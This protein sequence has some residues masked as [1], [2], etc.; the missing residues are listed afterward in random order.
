[1]VWTN[2]AENVETRASGH[3][4]VQNYGIRAKSADATYRFRYVACSSHK[5]D[6]GYV[7]QEVGQTLDNYLGIIRD[8]DSH[9]LSAPRIPT[10]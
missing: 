3:F 1:M 8:K 9:L 10:V 7:P 2:R 6:T 4:E 5:L